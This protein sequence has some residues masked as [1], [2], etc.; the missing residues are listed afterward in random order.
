MHK[1]EGKL[2]AKAQHFF[3]FP[4]LKHLKHFFQVLGGKNPAL[5]RADLAELAFMRNSENIQMTCFFRVYH[6]ID[7]LKCAS[8]SVFLCLSQQIQVVCFSETS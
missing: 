6:F 4:Y 7:F 3:S 8:I 2:H 1:R 5:L